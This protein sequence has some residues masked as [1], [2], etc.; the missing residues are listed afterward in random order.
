MKKIITVVLAVVCC[1]SMIIAGIALHFGLYAKE[2]VQEL[3]NCYIL[4]QERIQSVKDEVDL[5]EYDFEFGAASETHWSN[6]PVRQG[7]VEIE[8]G[9]RVPTNIKVIAS[10]NL[11]YATTN[12][13]I[14]MN[15][16][17]PGYLVVENTTNGM[18]AIL[19][20][21]LAS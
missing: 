11:E 9:L 6:V 17:Q 21:V 19:T 16:T 18:V 7:L 20:V 3:Y 5:S 10:Y 4:N 12:F 2:N 14:L 13:Y 15:Q 8:D 1:A